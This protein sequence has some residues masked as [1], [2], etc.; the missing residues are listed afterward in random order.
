MPTPA[1]RS[2]SVV[3]SPVT[4]EGLAARLSF[5]TIV[6]LICI[7]SIFVLHL[8]RL[9]FVS[10]A[11]A[12]GA[13]IYLLA[14]RSWREWL[15]VGA[16]ALALWSIYWFSGAKIDPMPKIDRMLGGQVCL[17]VAFLGLASVLILSW[18]YASEPAPNKERVA[19]ILGDVILLPGLCVISVVAVSTASHL[20]PLTC[21]SL[22]YAFDRAL[23]VDA[24][25]AAGRFFHW[26]FAV[27]FLCG[28]VYNCLPIMMGLLVGLQS[29]YRPAGSPDVRLVFV[30]LG[31]AGFLMYQLC[32][33]AGPRYL[34]G[35][36]FPYQPPQF[37]SIVLARVPISSGF[38]RN[39]MPSLHVGWCLLMVY[40]SW[41]R[42]RAMLAFSLV[43]VLLTAF[44]TLGS[45]EHYLTDLIV[46]FPLT[47]AVQ[48]GCE[49]LRRR[50]PQVIACVGITVAWLMALRTGILVRTA[51]PLVLW[52]LIVATIVIPAG[53]ALHMRVPS[54]FR[55]S[56]ARETD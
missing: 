25:F 38:P 27:L 32:P 40:N 52:A 18:R 33:A 5:I 6:A 49:D 20:S 31:V 42:S 11:F 3:D 48:L 53:V 10:Q 45:G 43:A 36:A 51:P 1:Y 47:V 37:A 54:W 15:L 29:R 44:A 39:A 30:A 14:S 55:T 35:A 41:R 4:T 23:G 19:A 34:V 24:A 12:G 2:Q 26:H 22:I 50:L 56:S 28:V 8:D 16:T 17:S 46:V 21:D 9:S 7:A 13:V